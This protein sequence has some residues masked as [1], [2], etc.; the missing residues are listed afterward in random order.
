MGGGKLLII[1]LI[2]AAFA[3]WCLVI[4]AGWCLI[5][6]GLIR[7]SKL[8]MILGSLPSLASFVLI[9][10]YINAM[11]PSALFKAEFGLSP[12]TEF[13]QL[14]GSYRPGWD[15]EKT[16]LAFEAPLAFRDKLLAEGYT[17]ISATEVESIRQIAPGWWSQDANVPARAFQKFTFDHDSH[18]GSNKYLILPNKSSS[19]FYF[20]STFD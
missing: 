19:I 14:R 7:K 12:S 10:F 8:W 1:Y 15:G 13:S 2:Q 18:T 3:L 4:L 20:D 6:F 16:F 9:A 17:E 11:R 5:L